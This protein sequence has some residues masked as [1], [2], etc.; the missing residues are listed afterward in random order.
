MA[1][2]DTRLRILT[3]PQGWDGASLAVRIL[4]SPAGNPLLPLDP[5]L[6]PFA[7]ANLKMS[8]RLIPSLDRL[9][10]PADVATSIR[11]N[12]STPSDL[13]TVYNAYAAKLSINPAAPPAYVAPTNTRIL[14]QVMPVIS[15]QPDS[16]GR[17]RNSP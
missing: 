3:F 13:L 17:G 14:K 4:V 16:T 2:I 9:P 7:Q 12:A 5:G 15:R 11:I 1:V 6:P 8:A 10:Q